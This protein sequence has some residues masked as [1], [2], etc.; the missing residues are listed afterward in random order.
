M[1][2][3]D[4]REQFAVNGRWTNGTRRKIKIK[5]VLSA[6]CSSDVDKKQ[7]NRRK[8]YH[9]TVRP[10]DEHHTRDLGSSMRTVRSHSPARPRAN[11][12]TLHWKLSKYICVCVRS[13]ECGRKMWMQC[14]TITTC[15]FVCVMCFVSMEIGTSQMKCNDT[16][17]WK[18]KLK[19]FRISE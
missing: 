2:V 13:A 12:Y 15:M 1:W 8:I 4:A 7:A 10:T 6:F 11:K 3:N 5:S 17:Q 14:L 16:K 19:Q 18:L 9:L